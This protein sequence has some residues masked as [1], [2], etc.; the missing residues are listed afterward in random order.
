MKYKISMSVYLEGQID[1]ICSL[2]KFTPYIYLETEGICIWDNYSRDDYILDMVIYDDKYSYYLKIKDQE[3][4][5][6]DIPI[7]KLTTDKNLLKLK[8]YNYERI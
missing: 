3:Y 7:E 2:L 1:F 5:V 6:D 8:K 4:T